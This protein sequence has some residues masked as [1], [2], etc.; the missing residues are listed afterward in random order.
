MNKK[1]IVLGIDGMDPRLSKKYLNKGIMPNLQKFI[2]KGSCRDDLV[3]LGGHPTVTPPMWTTLATGCYANVHGITAYWRQSPKD[4]DTV[5]YSLDSTIC[6]AEQIWNVLAENNYKTLVWHWPGSAWPPTSD[7]ENLFVVDGSC[8]GPVGM[9]TLMSDTDFIMQ[10]NEIYTEAKMDRIQADVSAACVMTDLDI[11]S[12]N[13]EKAEFRSKEDAATME[14]KRIITKKGQLSSTGSDTP[15]DFLT[16][17][18]KPATNWDIETEGLK[19]FTLLLSNG[20]IHRP[21]LI[22]KDEDGKFVKVA[23]YKNK[24]AIEPIAI[25]TKGVLQTEIVDEAFRGD[26]T[27][28]VT[29]SMKLLDIAEDGSNVKM[30][31]SGGYD[32]DND[33][34]FHPKRLQKEIYENIGYVTPIAYCGCQDKTFISEIQL[35]T[36]QSAAEWQAKAINYLIGKENL[37]V[38]FS[39]FHNVDLQAHTFIKHLAKRS[40]NKLPQE[41]YEKFM[42]DVYKQTDWYLGQFTHLL[43]E[44]WTIFIVSDHG[45]VASKHDMAGI[46]D[47]DGVTAL[48][49]KEL[50]FTVLKKDENGN[51]LPEIDWTKTTAVNCRECNIYLNLKGRTDHGIVDPA[52]KWQLEEDIITALYGYKDKETGQRI[53]SIALRNKDAVLLGYGGPECG[54]IC[55]WNA[56]GYNFDHA[57]CLS[58]SY[59]EG[60]TSVSP[61]FIAAGNGIK[62]GYKTE[63]IVREIDLVPTI[64]V[65]AGVRMPNQCEGAPV[66]QILDS[67][68]WK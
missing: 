21:C 55:F 36:W 42:E 4:I 16:T 28:R 1:I 52:D 11:T 35:P 5:E 53:V 2:A 22:L 10:A 64:A 63:R 14:K 9:G 61:I 39:H 33:S 31:V 41:D 7:S 49:M 29:R 57:D 66:Y 26:Q 8:P 50:G 62:T 18:I 67:E 68:Y 24:K 13:G 12:A 15:L 19:E 44:G 60:D 46:G 17:P 34:I 65:L 40:F 45:Q 56:E 30:Y 43:D 3:M 59:G 54:D 37:D 6:K 38:V 51:E 48:V 23:I 58:T 20:L 32:I 25:L 27:V 47:T